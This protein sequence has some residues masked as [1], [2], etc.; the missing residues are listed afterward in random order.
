MLGMGMIIKSLTP[1]I[2]KQLTDDKVRE[3]IET[4]TSEYPM[5]NDEVRN[6]GTISLAANG[7]VYFHIVGVNGS[8]TIVSIK[9]S[10][11]LVDGIKNLLSTLK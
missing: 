10:W 4:M 11:K 1:I 6:I 7:K 2:D 5:Q 8:N 3:I 9:K